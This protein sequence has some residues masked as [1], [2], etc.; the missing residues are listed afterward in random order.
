MASVDQRALEI[1]I[2]AKDLASA[3]FKKVDDAAKRT[4]D[5]I[6]KGF[7]GGV[8]AS[9]KDSV[10]ELKAFVRG[11][12]LLQG[13]RF[14]GDVISDWLAVRREIAAARQEMTLFLNLRGA[15]ASLR[16]DLEALKST[17]MGLRTDTGFLS[18]KTASAMALLGSRFKI[19]AEQ[20][21]AF[22]KDAVFLANTVAGYKDDPLAAL[23]DIL[24]AQSGIAGAADALTQKLQL[25]IKDETS[26]GNLRKE[27]LIAEKELAIRGLEAANAA[28]LEAD[29]AGRAGALAEIK[30]LQEDI[31]TLQR[32]IAKNPLVPVDPLAAERARAEKAAADQ[33]ERQNRALKEQAPLVREIALDRSDF[34]AGL[35]EGFE[36]FR[37]QLLNFREQGRQTVLS[38]VGGVQQ[39]GLAFVDTL[40][41]RTMSAREAL[42][43]FATDMLRML[44][45]LT[46]QLAASRILGAL[47]GAIAG[48]GT[49]GNG[50]RSSLGNEPVPGGNVGPSA[51]ASG[52]KSWSPSGGGGGTTNIYFQFV[53]G[54]GADELLVRHKQT[55][56]EI[57]A[58]GAGSNRDLR[59]AL[60]VR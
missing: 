52:L 39:I 8:L 36:E 10:T 4:S 47:F 40:V 46:A 16:E 45:Q 43:Q 9:I 44:A 50:Y 15:P 21:A 13:V 34:G 2:R 6:A 37:E 32:E 12:S 51:G 38:L 25:Q 57:V 22:A 55:I 41:T 14:L 48:A 53:D 7:K 35:S 17:L 58:A 23:N 11:F 33:I 59:V 42:R 56:M 27:R 30:S 31:L 20:A 54:T 19:T 28:R 29:V 3:D 5:S 24:K 1:L 49:G 26:L 18:E 60:G